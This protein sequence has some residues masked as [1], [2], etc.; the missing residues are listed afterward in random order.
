[1][2]GGNDEDADMGR[3]VD[4]DEDYVAEDDN[5]DDDNFYKSSLF[6]DDDNDSVDDAKY[7]VPSAKSAGAGRKP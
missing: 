4:K 5:D 2:S 7:H 3:E 6:D 1:M